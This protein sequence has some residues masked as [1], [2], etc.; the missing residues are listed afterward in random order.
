[1]RYATVHY[2]VNTVSI[3]WHGFARSC[4][5]YKAYANDH[6]HV[7]GFQPRERIPHLLMM[8]DVLVLPNS[9]RPKLSSHYTSPLKLFQYMASG[10]PIVAS[11]LPS[12]REILTNETCFWFTPDDEEALARQVEYVLTHPDE[13]RTKAAQA[14]EVV[15]RYTWDARAKAILASI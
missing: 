1:M 15:K 14:Q 7:I 10:I 3:F 11:Y 13:A 9:A 6:V 2:R 4:Y 8:A 12:I 5:V